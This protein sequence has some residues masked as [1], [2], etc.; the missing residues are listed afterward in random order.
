LALLSTEFVL[1]H[2][3]LFFLK[4]KLQ[5]HLHLSGGACAYSLSSV[6]VIKRIKREGKIG[7]KTD[8]EKE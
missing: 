3:K 2:F 6:V 5:A 8:P 7:D 1:K 4:L